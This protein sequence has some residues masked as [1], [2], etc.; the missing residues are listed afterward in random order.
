VKEPIWIDQRDA[1]ALHDGLLALLGGARTAAR[2]LAESALCPPL[3]HL[4]YAKSPNV[5]DLGTVYTSGIARNHPLVVATS[6]RGLNPDETGYS[7][8]LRECCSTEH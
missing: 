8:F 4:T 7:T 1:T 3:Q 6:V 5:V 2:G